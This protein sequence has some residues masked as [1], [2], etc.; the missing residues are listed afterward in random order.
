MTLDKKQVPQLAA[1]GVLAVMC[2][3]IV[4]FQVIR[5]SP[6]GTPVSAKKAQAKSADKQDD[7]SAKVNISSLQTSEFPNLA[8][9]PVR[10]DPFARQMSPLSSNEQNKKPAAAVQKKH[11]Y[12]QGARHV[13][14]RS[15]TIDLPSGRV[16]R[17]DV[18][19]MNPF[20]QTGNP[21]P[22]PINAEAKEPQF[23]L[24]GVIRGEKNVAIIRT[25]KDG[26]H[27][28]KTGQSVDGHYRVVNVSD[29]SVLLAD[30]KNHRIHVK[31]G[32]E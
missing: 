26:R 30:E 29:D 2:V 21:Q 14:E 16:P 22:L 13:N 28:V 24:T 15:R 32:G 8:L 7:S 19:P 1:L 17:I 23:V 11:H 6:S 27:V 12:M 20:S 18:K 5:N 31:L 4:S 10:R 25:G 3:G 9:L